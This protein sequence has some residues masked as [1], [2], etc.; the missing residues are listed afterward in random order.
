MGD[1]A[2]RRTRPGGSGF[3]VRPAK[4]RGPCGT[5]RRPGGIQ[6]AEIPRIEPANRNGTTPML[7]LALFFLL[8]IGLR[9]L[10][11]RGGGGGGG[12]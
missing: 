11:N 1:N 3:A 4:S 5:D 9:L 8:F 10:L 12:G 6:A 2:Y 7:K